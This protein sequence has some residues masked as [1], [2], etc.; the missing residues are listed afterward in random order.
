[1]KI[2]LI[3]STL[4]VISLAKSQRNVLSWCGRDRVGESHD[5]FMGKRFKFPEANEIEGRIWGGQPASPGQF[6]FYTELMSFDGRWMTPC[7]G[8]LIRYNWVLTV[9]NNFND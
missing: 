8:S 4:F 5:L 2:I 9:N 3:I 7:G 6:G 1:M